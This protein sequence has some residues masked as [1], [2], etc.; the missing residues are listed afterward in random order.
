MDRVRASGGI[1]N[2]VGKVSK[3]VEIYVGK[4]SKS[5]E[6]Y[7]GKVS[8]SVEIYVGKVSSIEYNSPESCA[9]WGD[10]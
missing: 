4:V 3:S 9:K 6:I 10:R 1:V 5:V 2:D 7:V 8:K